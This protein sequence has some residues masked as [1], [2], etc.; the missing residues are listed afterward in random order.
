MH[1][2]RCKPA[3]HNGVCDYRRTLLDLLFAASYVAATVALFISFEMR[4]INAL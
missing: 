3:L 4:A 2:P 1:I